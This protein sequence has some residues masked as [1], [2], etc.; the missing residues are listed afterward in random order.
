MSGE[1]FY[2]LVEGDPDSP[3][4]TFLQERINKIFIDNNISY[5]PQVE[6]VGGCS[7]FFN[8]YLTKVFYR[9]SKK[10]HKNIP[11]LAIADSDYRV[12]EDKKHEDNNKIIESK[13]SKILYW[14]RHEWENYLLEETQLIA[15]FVNQFPEKSQKSG[16]FYKKSTID[17]TKDDLDNHLKYYFSS[18][19]K[20]EFFE[21]LK[22]NLSPRINYPSISKPENFEKDNVETIE[23]WFLNYFKDKEITVK[24]KRTT[25]YT[26]IKNE[27]GWDSLV[28][29]PDTFSLDFAKKYFRGKEALNSLIDFISNEF[30]CNI[31]KKY[32]RI[33]LLKQMDNDSLIIK[34]LKSL[35]LKELQ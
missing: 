29:N 13:K 15:N 3:E 10:A 34:D 8:P 27:F 16:G 9:L 6:E 22:F 31:D 7:S 28:N 4:L 32:F 20:E 19:I 2:I 18:K 30:Q 35:L 24:P 1:L 21:C 23:N 25:L 11:V 17:I 26:E 33:E 12:R 14:Q 5:I